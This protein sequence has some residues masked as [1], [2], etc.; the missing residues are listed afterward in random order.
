MT[1]VTGQTIVDESRT[2]PR[3]EEAMPGYV[4][5]PVAPEPE[6]CTYSEGSGPTAL[7]HALR[8][9]WVVA[10]AVGT[11]CAA[12]AALS[13]WAL[14]EPAYTAQA[15]LRVSTSQ[16]SLVFETRDSAGGNNFGIYKNTQ[17]QLLT[18]EFVL[19]AALRN[20]K[21]AETAIVRDEPDPVRYLATALQVSFPGDSELMAVRLTGD[22]P[23]EVTAVVNA[24]VE[25]YLAEV[26]DREKNQRRQRLAELNELYVAKGD[27]MRRKRLELKQLAEQIGSGDSEALALKQQIA[28]EQFAELRRALA[29]AQFH[30][31]RLEGELKVHTEVLADDEA[32]DVDESVVEAALRR[33]PVFLALDRQR[34]ELQTR[35]GEYRR[36][37]VDDHA[38]Q[39]VA[40]PIEDLRALD[41]QVH[42]TRAAI[43]EDLARFK[44]VQMEEQVAELQS[45]LAVAVEQEKQLRK[46]LEA[47]QKRAEQFGGSSIDVEMMRA[48]ITQLQGILD[49]IAAERERLRVEMETAARVQ[50]LQSA[51]KPTTPDDDSTVLPQLL[52]VG[53]AGFGLPLAGILY[54]E[55][56]KQRVNTPAE[57]AERLRLRL[58]G[59]LPGAQRRRTVATPDDRNAT[60]DSAPVVAEALDGIIA[61]F[62]HENAQVGSTVVLVSSAAPGEGKTTLATLLATGLARVGH[63]TLLVDFDVRRPGLAP[64]FGIAPTP[65]V[66]E[67]LRGE[68][69]FDDAL[70]DDAADHLALLPAGIWAA[71]SLAVLTGGPT[72]HLFAEARR[73][74]DF[75]VVDGG[76]VLQVAE[77]RLLTRYA[78]R[79]VLSVLR[80][81]SCAPQVQAA[82]DMFSAFGAPSIEAVAAGWH[83]DM[84][85]SASAAAAHEHPHAV[86]EAR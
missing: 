73:R 23:D 46:D 10:T 63:A 86:A 40:R 68:A 22:D 15:M 53:M 25:A 5:W 66:G 39:Y 81:V 74:F 7:L 3:A 42:Q 51:R 64:I 6:T 85:A 13:I 57:V 54:W 4:P 2:A 70:H 27:E 17:Q 49:P 78:D 52:L 36:R 80:D 71:E 65:G 1:Q 24:V 61:R 8:R 14:H 43:R 50:L 37:V 67:I 56:R 26:V 9:R 12:L 11:A 41:A 28:L 62:L 60:P 33:N 32:I 75:V 58:L 38:G 55:T 29:E 76:P 47:S 48:E 21:V 59:T 83:D 31:R 77:S 18:S 20:Q 79:V 19:I 45:Q 82:R 69:T 35:I 44:R 84:Y 16:E 72:E 30:M 34:V